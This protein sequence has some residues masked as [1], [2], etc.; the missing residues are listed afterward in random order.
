MQVHKSASGDYA[1]IGFMF[2]L[3]PSANTFLDSFWSN[4]QNDEVLLSN[5]DLD[6]RC[7]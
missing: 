2:R 1:V 4:I 7:S 3:G 6:S 5:I